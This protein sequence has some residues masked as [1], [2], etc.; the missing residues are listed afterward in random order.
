MRFGGFG[1]DRQFGFGAVPTAV[2]AAASGG[3]PDWSS[4]V[5]LATANGADGATTFVDQSASAKTLTANGNAQEDSGIT[6]FQP[7]SIL[8][9]GTGDYLDT[10]DHADF[11][12]GGDFTV[13]AWIRADDFGNN[14]RGVIGQSVN[15]HLYVT[16]GGGI[17]FRLTSVDGLFGVQSGA[18]LSTATWHHVVADRASTVLR[19]YADGVMAA[20]QT[21]VTGA[22][23]ASAEALRV[24][25]FFDGFNTP[26]FDG[27]MEEVRITK[28]VARYASDAGYDVPTEAFPRA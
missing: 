16:N 21:G 19:V 20:K 3:D 6:H 9:D 7:F 23:A 17:N 8:L 2:A 5:L 14:W 11:Q 4:V 28:G 15:W 27:S 18:V 25:Y 12:F 10:P 13:E 26:Y 1:F 24:G 22:M